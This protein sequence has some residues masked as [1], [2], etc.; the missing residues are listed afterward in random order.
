MRK[1]G[2]RIAYDG[3]HYA[4][5]QRQPNVPTVQEHLEHNLS[6]ITKQPVTLHGSGRTDAGVHALGQVAHFATDVRMPA[7]KFALAANAGLPQDIRVM[8]SWEAPL[9]FHARYSARRKRYRYVICNAPVASALMGRYE[10]HLHTPLNIERMQRAVPLLVG[11]HDFS[12]F[13]GAGCHIEQRVRTVYDSALRQRGEQVI[14]EV[15][16]NGF[17]YNMVRIMVGT[18]VDIG[19]GRLEPAYISQLLAGKDRSYAGQT[20][21]AHGL[22]LQHVQYDGKERQQ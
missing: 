17:L 3:T 15:E 14:Y 1:I 12:A 13:T 8:E 9:D 11:E 19:Y 16:G 18:L 10:W 6:I 5:W 21:P 2:L 22:T 7:E 4:G 20:A